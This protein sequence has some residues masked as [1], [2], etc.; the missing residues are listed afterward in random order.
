ML[1]PR[2]QVTW[3]VL[4]GS[5]RGETSPIFH[6]R[7]RIPIE[8]PGGCANSPGPGRIAVPPRLTQSLTFPFSRRRPGRC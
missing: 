7:A 4:G 2:N 5:I 8:R 6:E 1:A 3:G